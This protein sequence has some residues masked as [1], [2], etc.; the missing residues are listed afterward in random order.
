MNRALA[1]MG[2]I[3]ALLLGAQAV[4][5]DSTNPPTARRQLMD[6]MNRRMSANKTLSFNQATKVCKE[7]Q[8]AKDAA[9]ASNNLQKTGK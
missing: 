4:A 8:K 6:C 5:V 2:V 3:G 9:L 1:A 7:Q